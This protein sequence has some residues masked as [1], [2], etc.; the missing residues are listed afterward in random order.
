MYV[1]IISYTLLDFVNKYFIVE[2]ESI[3]DCFQENITVTTITTSDRHAGEQMKWYAERNRLFKDLG[4]GRVPCNSVPLNLPKDQ[5]QYFLE[6]I[7]Y[8][9]PWKA[10]KLVVLGHGQIGK[11]TLVYRLKERLIR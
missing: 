1:F 2:M 11:S 10:M 7:E 6:A 9:E 3:H 8:S 4:L 5:I